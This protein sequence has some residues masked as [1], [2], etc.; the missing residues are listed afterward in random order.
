MTNKIFD[1]IENGNYDINN[2]SG[3]YAIWNTL[4]NKKYVGHSSNLK[5]RY[6]Q[7]FSDLVANRHHN[8]HLQFAFNKYGNGFFKFV[9]LEE[10]NNVRDT[11]L[12]IE[13]KYIDSSGDYNLSK[14]ANS[15]SCSVYTGHSISEDHKNIIRES[16]RN[17]KWSKETIRIKSELMRNSDI[18]A[19]QRK[20]VLQYT[21]DNK[22]VNDFD[23]IQKAGES[24]GHKNKRV[25]IKR[26]C[27]GKQK[28]A[29]NFKWYF[30][31]DK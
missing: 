10:C 19:R 20:S 24:M 25:N 15:P 27:Q 18:N 4:N 21:T 23:S 29:F 8:R 28:T 16:N 26:C 17:R 31:N 7:H 6:R 3:V 13:Q 14:I 5:K 9:I 2:S 11:L 30:K 1:F 22:F 12:L